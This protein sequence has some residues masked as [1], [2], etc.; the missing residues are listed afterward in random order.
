MDFERGKAGRIITKQSPFQ[1][2]NGKFLLQFNF[3]EQF[4]VLT[5]ANGEELCIWVCIVFFSTQ[6]QVP[7]LIIGMD[8]VI[9]HI[10]TLLVVIRAFQKKI[11]IFTQ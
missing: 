1:S 10:K 11:K 8:R 7:K 9:Y 6:L 4:F 2:E 3:Y 5:I